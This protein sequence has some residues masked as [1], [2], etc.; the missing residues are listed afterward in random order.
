MSKQ[1]S[2]QQL[3]SSNEMAGEQGFVAL[4]WRRKGIS[5]P[6]ARTALISFG[7]LKTSPWY[8]FSTAF[9]F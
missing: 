3:L 2:W 8:W 1:G 9:N 6:V 5:H 7:Q 4:F